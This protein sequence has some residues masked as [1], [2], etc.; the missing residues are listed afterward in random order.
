VVL[1]E[2]AFEN[3]LLIWHILSNSNE[4]SLVLNATEDKIPEILKS[5]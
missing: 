5:K 4:I 1:R 2:S 3:G